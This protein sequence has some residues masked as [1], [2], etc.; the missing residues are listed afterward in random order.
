MMAKPLLRIDLSESACD[1]EPTAT[2]PGLPMLDRQGAADAILFRWLGSFVAEPQWQPDG[3][4]RFFVRQGEHGRLENVVAQPI[5]P[6]DLKGPLKTDLE[7]FTATID[8]IRPQSSD[9]RL[10]A[11]IVRQ[12]TERF[13]TDPDGAD[14][15]WFLFKYR[16]DD[17]PWR[18]VW[19]WGYQPMRHAPAEAVLC[20][21]DECRLLYLRKP[22][23]KSR[24]PGC[25][26]LCDRK[27]GR[28]R[29]AVWRRAAVW[30]LLLAGIAAV[31]WLVTATRNNSPVAEGPASEIVMLE[32][33]AITAGDRL[34]ATPNAVELHPHERRRIQITAR[35]GEP[36]EVVNSAPDLVAARRDGTLAAV[37]EGTADVIYRQGGDE[38][39]VRVSV[40][41]EEIESIRFDVGT[42]ASGDPAQDRKP[43]VE[44]ERGGDAGQFESHAPVIAGKTR[45]AWGPDLVVVPDDRGAHIV[46]IDRRSPLYD[47]GARPGMWVLNRNGRPMPAKPSYYL[48]YPPQADDEFALDDRDAEASA[49]PSIPVLLTDWRI[50]R[51]S[52]TDLIGEFDIRVSRAAQYRLATIDGAALCDW[53]QLHPHTVG[54][55]TSTTA[56]PLSPSDEYEVLVQRRTA[57]TKEPASFSIYFAVE[58]R[59][60]QLGATW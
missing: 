6:E 57:E 37:G 58:P 8:R 17:G 40:I 54:T 20:P 28:G 24:C 43:P 44:Q 45:V 21:N 3:S 4:A 30:L 23:S 38:S 35:S 36:V 10:L 60:P 47:Q 56:I 53:R 33:N 22:R 9:E 11:K 49:S 12:T 2:E 34:A 14:F 26:G 48:E 31:V 51:Q 29:W 1:F 25:Q 19:C 50:V 46:Q 52:A 18:L 39:V 41:G 27:E 55:L 16:Q 13:A 59:E 7:Q 15:D 32:E 5:A 42:T